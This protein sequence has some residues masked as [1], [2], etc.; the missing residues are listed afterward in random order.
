MDELVEAIINKLFAEIPRKKGSVAP[1]VNLEMFLVRAS[2]GSC[3]SSCDATRLGR[4]SLR[5][6]AQEKTSIARSVI[7]FDSL[8][9]K[10]MR[11]SF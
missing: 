5:F 7:S 8:T 11:R 4:I 3:R 1:V 10:I 2:K 6:S 9:L